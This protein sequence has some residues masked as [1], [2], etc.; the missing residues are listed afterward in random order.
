MYR[1]SVRYY[2]EILQRTT[3]RKPRRS[4]ARI[5]TS[6]V[7]GKKSLNKM[8]HLVGTP[9]EIEYFIEDLEMGLFTKSEYLESFRR[10]GLSPH[11]DAKGLTGRGL[12]IGT[13]RK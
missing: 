11:Y 12:Y 6:A 8:D 1:E 2:D 13:R 5:A 7:H 9:K 3:K 10:G 4:I